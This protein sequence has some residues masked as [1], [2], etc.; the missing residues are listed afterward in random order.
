MIA[1]Q[2]NKTEWGKVSMD[3]GA[4]MEA[5]GKK[6]PIFHSRKDFQIALAREIKSLYPQAEICREVPWGTGRKCIDILVIMN[7][8]RYPIRLKYMTKKLDTVRLGEDFSLAEQG[9]QDIG[10][11]RCIED[12]VLLERFG[13]QSD[14]VAGYA[15]WLTNDLYYTRPPR[16]KDVGYYDF[17]IHERR[18]ING[19]LAWRDGVGP[20]TRKGR[21]AALEVHGNY[22]V[23]WRDYSDL[24]T[25]NGLF[26]YA[27]IHIE[28]EATQNEH[29]W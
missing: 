27:V 29:I 11:Y 13:D 5:L 2:V 4:I 18:D 24:D 22:S 3:I 9:A 12:M 1:P 26:K 19:C 23:N 10:R 6:R 7:E 17:S 25:E 14:C 8:K 28:R 21:E 16:Q 20:G 15:I